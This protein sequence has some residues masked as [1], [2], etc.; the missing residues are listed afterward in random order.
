MIPY[1]VQCCKLHTSEPPPGSLLVTEFRSFSLEKLFGVDEFSTRTRMIT[2][3][4]GGQWFH[5]LRKAAIIL[6]REEG[7]DDMTALRGQ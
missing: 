1:P 4:D 7:G 5:P 6:E 2:S 3:M